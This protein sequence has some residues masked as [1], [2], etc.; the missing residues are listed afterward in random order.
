MNLHVYVPVTNVHYFKH[1]MLGHIIII[2]IL[3]FNLQS[4]SSKK[5]SLTYNQLLNF[6]QNTQKKEM[7]VKIEIRKWIHN[8]KAIIIISRSYN[9]ISKCD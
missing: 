3:A 2:T 7:K 8:I 5:K 6:P 1:K 4:I 9:H